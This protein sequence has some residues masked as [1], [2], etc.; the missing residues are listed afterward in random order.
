MPVMCAAPFTSFLQMTGL[1]GERE[2]KV[3]QSLVTVGMMR[4]AYWL[5]WMVWEIMLAFV[6][7][8]LSIA[9]G[10]ICQ[11]DFFLKN[12]FWIVFFTLFIFQL[13][14]VGFAYFLAAFIRKSSLAI[15]LGFVMFLV[16]FVFSVCS[17]V[18]YTL[19]LLQ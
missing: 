13:A 4:S 7:T 19:G 3:T 2:T 1:I 6:V 15:S 5:S 11:I 12:D 17:Q 14:M 10:A 9:F 18:S 16:G 8:L